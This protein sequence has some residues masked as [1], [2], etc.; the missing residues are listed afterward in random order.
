MSKQKFYVG[1]VIE[2]GKEKLFCLEPFSISK[3]LS[4]WQVQWKHGNIKKQYIIKS[5]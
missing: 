5:R 4:V 2:I 3:N 1:F